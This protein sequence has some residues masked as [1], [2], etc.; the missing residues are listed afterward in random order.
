MIE[1]VP[2]Y[3]NKF[4]E[5]G[6]KPISNQTSICF[7]HNRN[8]NYCNLLPPLSHFCQT[9]SVAEARGLG[10]VCKLLQQADS[11]FGVRDT[12]AVDFEL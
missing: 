10:A 8:S 7:A 11:R 6:E 1:R 12:E 9:Q 4:R 3:W 2:E 5:C